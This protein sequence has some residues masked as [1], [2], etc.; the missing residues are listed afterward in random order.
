MVGREGE[1]VHQCG[2]WSGGVC[3]CALNSYSTQLFG[4]RA[5]PEDVG[6]KGPPN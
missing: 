6:A 3:M 1:L 4:L 5:V 2:E